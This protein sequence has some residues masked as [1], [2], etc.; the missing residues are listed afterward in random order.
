M[1]VDESLDAFTEHLLGGRR[2]PEVAQKICDT[3]N[4]EKY[5]FGGAFGNGFDVRNGRPY[6]LPYLKEINEAHGR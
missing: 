5:A 1:T 2:N 3:W 4:R 6:R